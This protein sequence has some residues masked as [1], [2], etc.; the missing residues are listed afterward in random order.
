VSG[1]CPPCASGRPPWL[2]CAP[3]PRSMWGAPEHLSSS[4][5][6]LSTHPHL[7]LCPCS[8]AHATVVVVAIAELAKLHATASLSLPVLDSSRHH[9]RLL[10]LHALRVSARPKPTG[11]VWP[12]EPP[13]RCHR[14]QP[15]LSHLGL[16]WATPS[17]SASA[18]KPPWVSPPLGRHRHCSFLRECGRYLHC[19]P[20]Q[21]SM[22]KRSWVTSS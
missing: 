10:L 18:H 5:P 22:P 17:S 12:W 8:R 2:T 19:R 9:L 16:P 21:S 14:R 15:Q 11:A 3:A 6:S 20:K 13:L 7:P 1:A 4:I